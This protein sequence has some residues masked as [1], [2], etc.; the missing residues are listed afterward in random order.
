MKR[1]LSDNCNKLCIMEFI[2]SPQ[3]ND[4]NQFFK[5]C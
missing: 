5:D 1:N 4:N 3:K 2:I